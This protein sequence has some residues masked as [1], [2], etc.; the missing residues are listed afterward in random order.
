MRRKSKLN[1]LD[2]Y[3]V[4]CFTFLILFTIVMTVIF[5]IKGAVPDALIDMVRW[6]VFGE[7]FGC[8]LIKALNIKKEEDV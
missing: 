4:F 8:A 1:K 2:R 5:C 3:L 6:A 7:T